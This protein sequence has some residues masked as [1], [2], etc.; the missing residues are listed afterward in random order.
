MNGP[1]SLCVMGLIM[2]SCARYNEP[3]LPRKAICAAVEHFDELQ[4]Q[5]YTSVG[6]SP[7]AVQAII[8]GFHL[9]TLNTVIK[10]T[11]PLIGIVYKVIMSGPA[12]VVF[13]VFQRSRAP[14]AWK[15]LKHIKAV[16]SAAFSRTLFLKIAGSKSPESFPVQL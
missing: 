15:S 12:K 6:R 3:L 14:T 1:L 8:L 10:L 9:P 11:T 5:S 4:N 13:V 2:V 7:S 16:Y